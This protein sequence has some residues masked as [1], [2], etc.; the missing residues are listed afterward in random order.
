M[1]QEISKAERYLRKADPVL[2][3]LIQRHGPCTLFDA[4]GLVHKSGFH[5]LAWAIINQ[6]LSVASAR[7]I[8]QRLLKLN[9][10]DEF[11]AA[12]INRVDDNSLAACGL[13]RQ[14]I[15]YLRVLCEAVSSGSLNLDDLAGEANESISRQL[16]ALPGIGPWTVDMYLMFSLGRLDVLP[17]GDLALRKAFSLHYPVTA[18]ATVQEYLRLAESWRPYRTVASWYLWASV[19]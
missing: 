10:A 9:Q 4:H 18:Q 17:V 11:S 13:S 5:A 15:R 6:Q 7:S 12:R 14:K 16:S 2:A 19:D 3:S 1:Q 8:E